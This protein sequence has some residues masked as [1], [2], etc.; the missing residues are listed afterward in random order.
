MAISLDEIRLSA[1]GPFLEVDIVLV[2]LGLL[3]LC[4][5]LLWLIG[6]AFRAGP[7]WG[8]LSFIPPLLLVFMLRHWRL[9]RQPLLMIGLGCIPVAVGISMIAA[10]D[11]ELLDRLISSDWLKVHQAPQLEHGIA[12]A[13]ELMGKPFRPDT[14]ELIDGIL[15]LSD[16]KAQNGLRELS[17][18]LPPIAIAENFVLNVLPEDGGPKPE[19]EITWSRPLQEQPDVLRLRDGYTL[20]LA[21][22]REP[23]NKLK[24]DFH[25]ALPPTYAT[26]LSGV[27][28]L[29]TDGLRYKEGRVD[30]SRDSHD[31]LWY[32]IRDYLER[33]HGT[34]DLALPN[35]PALSLVE[36]QQALELRVAVQ[37]KVHVE[38]IVLRKDGRGWYVDGDRY[39]ALPATVEPVA[40]PVVAPHMVPARVMDS[41]P[42]SL[43]AVLSN[44]QAYLQL[45]VRI[46]SDKGRIAEGLFI[47]ID[48][49]GNI[50][51][52]RSDKGPG[53]VVYRFRP[54]QIESIERLQPSSR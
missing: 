42:L 37:G 41:G 31:T 16:S 5:G 54:Q 49:L 6:R 52:K 44:P 36:R 3:L 39:A 43:D 20:H 51:V 45:P 24:G 40:E 12:L 22:E 34:R 26:L 50:G 33:R 32:V 8:A 27:V 15:T 30:R 23:P 4:A 14:G 48:E 7:A 1:L 47:G 10:R 53:E 13:G 11:P 29:Y 18:R 25:L 35:E 17:L 38:R 21:L 19:V 9:A 28:E 2:L 46:R